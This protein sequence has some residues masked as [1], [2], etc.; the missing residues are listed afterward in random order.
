MDQRDVRTLLKEHLKELENLVRFHRGDTVQAVAAIH[1]EEFWRRTLRFAKLADSEDLSPEDQVIAAHMVKLSREVI[2]V[3]REEFVIHA[4]IDD[5]N[6]WRDNEQ[7]GD[8]GAA[9][10][11][12]IHKGPPP[13]GG[14][15]AKPFPPV[16]EFEKFED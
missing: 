9:V 1:L 11:A 5:P 16:D 4:P 6:Q 12:W 14:L 13:R 7:D 2:T 15:D 10:G 3:K 8:G